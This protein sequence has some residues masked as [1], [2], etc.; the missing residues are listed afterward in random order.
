MSFAPPQTWYSALPSALPPVLPRYI[1]NCCGMVGTAA[2]LLTKPAPPQAKSVPPAADGASVKPRPE[3]TF[4]AVVVPGLVV[5]RSG[6][7]IAGA[8]ASEMLPLSL[9]LSPKTMTLLKSVAAA[10]V[11]NSRALAMAPARWRVRSMLILLGRDG[12][13]SWTLR[14]GIP[15]GTACCSASPPQAGPL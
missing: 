12:L 15:Y 5:K 8:V 13:V 1:C 4:S 10:A 7:W 6:G 11:L 14:Y 3:A 2:T 9:R